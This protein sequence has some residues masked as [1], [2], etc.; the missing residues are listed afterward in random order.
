MAGTKHQPASDLAFRLEGQDVTMTPFAAARARTYL[1][2]SARESK[3]FRQ[4]DFAGCADR[5]PAAGTHIWN[6]VYEKRKKKILYL[7]V[8]KPDTKLF[9]E[10]PF[11]AR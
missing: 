2:A 5:S 7:E 1:H 4:Q 10:R 6:H 3:P 11:L 8:A 9:A